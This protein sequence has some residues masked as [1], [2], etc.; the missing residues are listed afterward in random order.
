MRK[1]IVVQKSVNKNPYVN[2]FGK[3]IRVNEADLASYKGMEI[4]YK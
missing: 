3:Y 1:R 4:V 2:V